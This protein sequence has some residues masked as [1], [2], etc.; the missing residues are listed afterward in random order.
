MKFISEDDIY[1]NVCLIFYFFFQIVPKI[2]QKCG[3]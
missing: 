1:S 2:K 3:I